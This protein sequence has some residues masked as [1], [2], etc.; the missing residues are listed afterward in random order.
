MATLFIADLHLQTEEPA[1][2]A[3]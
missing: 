3:G 1:I 2:T